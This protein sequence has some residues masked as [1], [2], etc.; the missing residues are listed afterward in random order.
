MCFHKKDKKVLENKQKSKYIDK[1]FVRI[2]LSSILILISVLFNNKINIKEEINKNY[3]FL[4]LTRIINN[5][6]GNFIEIK[7]QTV[8]NANVFDNVEFDGKFNIITNNNFNGVK[9]LTTGVI[10]KIIR[11]KKEGL[12]NITVLGSDNYEYTYY[13]IKD[14]HLSLYTYVNQETILGTMNEEEGNFRFR[15]SIYKDSKYYNF[16]ELCED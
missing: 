7:D 5:T 2:F 4:N 10:T 9:C 3:N 14:F 8:Y 1:L 15:L 13:D 11:N 16:Y 6:F 12:Y